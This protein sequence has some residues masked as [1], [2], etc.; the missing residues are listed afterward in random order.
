MVDY[1]P[2]QDTKYLMYLDAN[3]LYGHSMM[4]HLP[5]DMFIWCKENFTA[6]RILS[7]R[8]ESETGYILEVDLD[9]PQELHDL[10]RDYPLCAENRHVPRTKNEKK[11]FLTVFDKKIHVIHFRMVECALQNG[12]IFQNQFFRK[13]IKS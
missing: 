1:D 10:H 8:D 11:L 9:Y 2:S 5:L 6:E 4:Q 13:C 7:L 12:L 3:N